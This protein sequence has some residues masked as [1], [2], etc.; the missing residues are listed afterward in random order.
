[1]ALALGVAVPPAPTSGPGLGRAEVLVA[2]AVDLV[3]DARL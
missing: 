3:F 1:M 2:K